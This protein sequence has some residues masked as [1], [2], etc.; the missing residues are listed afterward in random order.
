MEQEN[1]IVPLLDDIEESKDDR[2]S[3]L[4]EIEEADPRELD[5]KKFKANISSKRA[6]LEYL[7]NIR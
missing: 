7:C 1:T 6:L 3:G 5:P 2:M 4:E